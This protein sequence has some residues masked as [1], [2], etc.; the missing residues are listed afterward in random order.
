MTKDTLMP[1]DATS[2]DL[3]VEDCYSED[4]E[5]NPVL[6]YKRPGKL[7]ETDGLE[8]HDFCLS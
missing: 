6:I 2:V 4:T 8:K 1:N 5:D 3:W 7:T